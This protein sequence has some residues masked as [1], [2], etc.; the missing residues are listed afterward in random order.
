MSASPFRLDGRRALV[1]GASR[2]IGRAIA[3]ALAEAGAE[4]LLH[5]RDTAAL[6]DAGEAV[7]AA[8]GDVSLFT[9]ELGDR[10]ATRALARQ[11]LDSGPV[12]ILVNNAG[13]NIRRSLAEL[14]DADWDRV[15]EVD[16]ASA[17]VL[18]KECAP[19]MRARGR[20]RIIN[21]GSIM[22][23]ISRP[24]ILAYTAAKHG[25][26]GLTKGL[27]AELGEAGITVNAIGPGF[28]HTA[29]TQVH[30]GEFADMV[31]KRTPA[32]R[33]G[34]PE[35]IGGAAVF[36]ASDAAAYVNGHLLVV[37]GGFSVSI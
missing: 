16:L 6:H 34:Q 10:A 27:A 11:V 31:V 12:D 1:T 13:I 15:M 18:A 5:G 2:G 7:R 25:L 4:L 14:T 29:A 24:G 22:S 8:G 20:G 37:D 30:A 36:L 28:V 9:G 21:I 3:R 26:V 32:K 33:W 19:G 23:T 35:D 17:V